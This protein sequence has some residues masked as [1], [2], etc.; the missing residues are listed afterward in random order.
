MRIK[1]TLYMD[2]NGFKCHRMGLQYS[3]SNLNRT[4]NKLRHFDELSFFLKIMSHWPAAIKA[5]V[6]VD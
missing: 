3:P 6:P 4:D 2:D 5:G 1:L